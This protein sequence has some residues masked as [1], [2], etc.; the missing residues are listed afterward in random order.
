MI[1]ILSASWKTCSRLWLMTMTLIPRSRMVVT[2]SSTRRPS[3]TPSAAM[4]SSMM[5]NRTLLEE[6]PADRHGLALAT[7]QPNDGIVQ[8]GQ[9]DSESGKQFD[10]PL[11]H[12]PVI[13]LR[14]EREQLRQQFASEKDVFGDIEC[15]NQTQPLVQAS[16]SGFARF[17]RRIELMRHAIYLD[18]AKV[19]RLCAGDCLDE[20]GLPGTVVADKRQDFALENLK[21]N[22]VNSLQSTVAL[23]QPDH[24]QHRFGISGVGCCL[25][26]LPMLFF[27]MRGTVQH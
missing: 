2:S 20:G 9:G 11:A 22:I 23:C 7:R 6:Q 24:V 26:H 14:D 4:G 21:G 10:G 3:S 1:A 18:A 17:A 8:P 12:S 19:G 25:S 27:G 16:D 5:T 13:Q 15:V